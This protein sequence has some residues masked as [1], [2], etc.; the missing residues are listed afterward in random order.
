MLYSIQRVMLFL[1]HGRALEACLGC[2]KIMLFLHFLVVPSSITSVTATYSLLWSFSPIAIV[3]PLFVVGVAQVVGLTLNYAGCE[4]SWV[5]R[6]AAAM[7][8]IAIWTW[9]VLKSALISSGG[10]E[11]WLGGYLVLWN[12]FI[13]WKA[14]NRLPVPG[15]PGL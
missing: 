14:F 4:W 13:L 6:A 9:I 10:L 3:L 7:G 8:G 5:V 1:G 2:A 12:I 11:A 15:A